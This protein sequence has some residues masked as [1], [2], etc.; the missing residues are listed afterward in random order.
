[1]IVLITKSGKKLL[2]NLATVDPLTCLT[3]LPVK[4]N[5]LLGHSCLTHIEI[6]IK[7]IKNNMLCK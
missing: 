3:L 1:M 7:L 2:L 4:T 5:K 6:Y